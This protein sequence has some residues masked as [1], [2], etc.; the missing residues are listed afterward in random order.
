[1]LALS[2][3]LLRYLWLFTVLLL[4]ACSFMAEPILQKPDI[5]LR[6]IRLKRAT[7]LEQEFVIDFSVKNPNAIDLPV[8]S[9]TY[10][11]QLNEIALFKG[12]SAHD[13][14]VPAK[15]SATFSVTVHSNLWRHLRNIRQML[16]EPNRPVRYQLDG[17]IKTALF[18]GER[19]ELQRTGAFIPSSVSN[20]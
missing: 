13:F 20:R 7:L 8:R 18:F 12:E 19:I 2:L 10:R 9:L 4:S 11:I 3:P 16:D 1:M 15:S 6:D 14:V 5:Q 17:E